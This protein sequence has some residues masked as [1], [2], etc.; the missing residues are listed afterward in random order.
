VA[1]PGCGKEPGRSTEARRQLPVLP[2]HC[3]NQYLLGTSP[4]CTLSRWWLPQQAHT[5]RRIRISMSP[6]PP[7]VPAREQ[8]TTLR[9]RRAGV[10]T[11]LVGTGARMGWWPARRHDAGGDTVLNCTFVREC[12]AE[13][14]TLCSFTRPA[15]CTK[16]LFTGPGPS[17]GLTAKVLRPLPGFETKLFGS[18]EQILSPV[19]S[20]PHWQTGTGTSTNRQEHV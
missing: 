10:Y 20:V 3:F 11:A 12:V 4:T 8:D 16:R 7:S 13:N 17:R 14:R 9:A 1:V 19:A 18:R 2:A 6:D 15:I 5:R